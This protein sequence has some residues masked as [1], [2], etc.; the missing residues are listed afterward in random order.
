MRHKHYW[1]TRYVEIEG[2]D[3]ASGMVCIKC[4]EEMDQ[5]D[6]E[7]ILNGESR[8]VGPPDPGNDPG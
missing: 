8:T 2:V 4:G 7:D 6:V 5:L 3:C 1:T